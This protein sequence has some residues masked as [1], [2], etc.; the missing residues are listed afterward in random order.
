METPCH[1]RPRRDQPR[2]SFC[3]GVGSFGREKRLYPSAQAYFHLAT[4]ISPL[5]SFTNTMVYYY[6]SIRR[7]R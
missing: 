3:A 7:N 6:D 1:D 2:I 5:P 4:W